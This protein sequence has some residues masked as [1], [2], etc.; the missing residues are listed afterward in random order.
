MVGVPRGLLC[1]FKMRYAEKVHFF[2]LLGYTFSV[3]VTLSLGLQKCYAPFWNWQTKLKKY[4]VMISVLG[5]LL[6]TFKM[7]FSRNMPKNRPFFIFGTP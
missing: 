1:T 4:F 2:G 3:I 6:H 5:G 7:R